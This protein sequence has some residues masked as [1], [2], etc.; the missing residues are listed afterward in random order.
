MTYNLRVEVAMAYS[1][2]ELK[3]SRKPLDERA[4]AKSSLTNV[5]VIELYC[6]EKEYQKVAELSLAATKIRADISEYEI[7]EKLLF[8]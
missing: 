3:Q 6:A 1:T 4:I 8:V 5:E 2:D 7:I